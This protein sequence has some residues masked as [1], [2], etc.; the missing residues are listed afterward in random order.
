[1]PTSVAV[2]W[3]VDLLSEVRRL[4]INQERINGG[5]FGGVIINSPT[6]RLLLHWPMGR[7]LEHLTQVQLLLGLAQNVDELVVHLGKEDIPR[8][9]R[10][11][12]VPLLLHQI[13]LAPI[14]VL[15]RPN[16]PIDV[17]CVI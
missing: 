15:L 14:L 10:G 4:A 1:M 9:P 16:D 11:L 6:Q 5:G 2:T 3:R 8:F 17:E 12:L 13:G 7:L